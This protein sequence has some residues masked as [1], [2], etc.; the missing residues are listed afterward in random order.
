MNDKSPKFPKLLKWML[1]LAFGF[2][3]LVVLIVVITS[4]PHQISSWKQWLKHR[5]YIKSFSGNV[6]I[7]GDTTKIYLHANDY[8]KDKFYNDCNLDACPEYRAFIRAARKSSSDGIL[9]SQELTDIAEL[10]TILNSTISAKDRE[11]KE[12]FKK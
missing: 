4:E 8:Y 12:K 2:L 1:I 3:G 11:F 9:T 10:Q 7:Y 6:M 5:E